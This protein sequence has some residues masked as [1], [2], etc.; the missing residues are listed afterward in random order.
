MS[1]RYP[2]FQSCCALM[3]W[4]TFF[5]RVSKIP[6][7]LLFHCPNQSPGGIK[8]R[9]NNKRMGVRSGTPDYMLAVP[10]GKHHGLFVEMKSTDGVVSEEQAKTLALLKAQGYATEVCYSTDSARSTIESYLKQ[11]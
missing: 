11:T 7:Q 4:W 1:S 10:R 6:E 8:Y 5:S 9:A 3:V 2:E